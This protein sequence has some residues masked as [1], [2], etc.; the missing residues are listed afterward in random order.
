MNDSKIKIKVAGKRKKKGWVVRG[1]SV[2]ASMENF[3]KGNILA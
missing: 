2:P 3:T 1:G